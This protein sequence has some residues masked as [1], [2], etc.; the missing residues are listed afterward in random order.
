MFEQVQVERKQSIQKKVPLNEYISQVGDSLT[1]H[2]YSHDLAVFGRKHRSFVIFYVSQMRL[3]KAIC[4]PL[5]DITS[6]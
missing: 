6:S 1:L 2:Y 4:P 5:R 3:E